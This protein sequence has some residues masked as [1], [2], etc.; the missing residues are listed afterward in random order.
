MVLQAAHRPEGC[1][2][3]EQLAQLKGLAALPRVPHCSSSSSGWSQ[4]LS[5]GR[6][7]KETPS[8]P[9]FLQLS[10]SPWTNADLSLPGKF[11]KSLQ[12]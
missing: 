1:E 3:G 12:T 8:T 9:L 11:A 10:S 4:G 2:R 7:G 5:P 6:G